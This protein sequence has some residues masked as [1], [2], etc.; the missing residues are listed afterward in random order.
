[1]TLKLWS[2]GKFWVAL[3]SNNKLTYSDFQVKVSKVQNAKMNIF[4]HKMKC[5]LLSSQ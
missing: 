3:D 4:A 5:K 2:L 1:M